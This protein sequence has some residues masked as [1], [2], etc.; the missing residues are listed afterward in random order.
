MVNFEKIKSGLIE[1]KK[2]FK[3]YKKEIVIVIIFIMR[4][5]YGITKLNNGKQIRENWINIINTMGLYPNRKQIL[6]APLL[7]SSEGK[8]ISN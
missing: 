5:D 7:I 3:K 6:L 2:D 1:N 8:T 4:G